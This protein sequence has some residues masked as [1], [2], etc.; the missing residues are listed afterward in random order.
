MDFFKQFSKFH[1]TV[2]GAFTALAGFYAVSQP[3]RDWVAQLLALYKAHVPGPLQPIPVLAVALY[4]WHH[5]GQAA[6]GQGQ[7]APVLKTGG[8]G[9]IS[10]VFL[11]L[12]LCLMVI[13]A[14]CHHT[15]NSSN[16]AVVSAVTLLDA[17]NTVNTIA[18]GL[19]TANGTLKSLQ[20]IEP[21]YYAYAHPKLVQIAQLNEKA[22][23]AILAAKNGNT[24]V[25]W[26]SAVIA[27]G[28]VATDPQSLVVF[29]F[30]NQSSQTIVQTSFAALL[31]GIAAAQQFG[32]GH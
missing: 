9:R 14:G 18:H 28:S 31:A 19:Q 15:V 11:T 6:N 17:E 26:K 32:G 30:K 27:I 21:D 2:T 10:A 7:S 1:N 25:D 13:F 23:Q 12:V 4:M 22:N 29:G 3:F 20:S 8:F 24:T 5:N 16:P